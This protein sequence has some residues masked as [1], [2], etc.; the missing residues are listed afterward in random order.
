MLAD[1]SLLMDAFGFDITNKT[2]SFNVNKNINKIV[3]QE[4]DKT[5]K[6]SQR[7]QAFSVLLISDKWNSYWWGQNGYLSH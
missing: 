4:L 1:N 7:L 3:M 2:S 5:I 6:E